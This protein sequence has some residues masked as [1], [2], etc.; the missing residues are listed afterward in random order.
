MEFTATIEPARPG[1]TGGGAVVYLPADVAASF[2]T[3]RQVRVKGSVNGVAYRS[4]LMPTGDGGFC[5]GVHKATREAAGATFGDAVT[6]T[7][8]R[9]DEPRE[10]VV[11]DDLAAALRADPVAAAAW[12]RLAPSHRREHANAVADAKKPET[13]A[14]RVEKTL[15][16]LRAKG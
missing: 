6:V 3:R 14:R 7:V 12:E 5:L 8:E 9:D 16:A 13:R 10:I 15:E 4:N 11:P 1:G 2:G